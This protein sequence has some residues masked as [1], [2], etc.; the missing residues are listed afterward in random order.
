MEI[1]SIFRRSNFLILIF[2][3]L[4]VL[5]LFC[6]V[7]D[8]SAASFSL[9]VGEESDLSSGILQMVILITLLSVAPSLLLMVTS[10]TRIIVS[11]SL[12]RT[13]IGLQQSPP[14]IVLTALSFFLTVFIMT[15][16]ISKIY[17]DS[18]NPLMTNSISETEA[19]EKAIKPVHAFMIKNVRQSD[20]ATFMSIA[21]VGKDEIK[22]P[23]EV[24]LEV[25]L[26]AFII[27]ELKKAFEIGFLIFLPFLVIDLLVSSVLLAMG[28]MMLPPMT[29]SLPLKLIFFVLIDGWNIVSESLVKSFIR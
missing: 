21:N 8:L 18:I 25:I 3:S 16:T 26:P 13:A 22:T 24:P 23:E 17:D 6:C 5:F 7:R 29:I 28:M 11:L 10:F 14:N 12:L 1:P 20:L 4:L 9:N 15:P 19:L 2:F 27:G